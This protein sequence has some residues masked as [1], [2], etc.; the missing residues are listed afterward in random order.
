MLP[1][2]MFE[3]ISLMYTRNKIGPI[4][5]PW[6]TPNE[7]GFHPEGTSSIHET[8]KIIQLF[9]KQHSHQGKKHSQ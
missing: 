5:E 7:T 4:R 8:I 6:G 1:V 3:S 2:D 9:E